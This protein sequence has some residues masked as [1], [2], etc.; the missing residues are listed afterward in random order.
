MGRPPLIDNKHLLQAAREV[1]IK[2]GSSGSTREIAKLLGISEAAIFKRYPTKASLFL[3]AMQPPRP[4]M[5]IIFAETQGSLPNL[6]KYRSIAYATVAY[7]RLAIPVMLP[8][9][10]HPDIG[11]DE[12]LNHYG[13]NPA[14]E[15]TENIAQWLGK[16]SAAQNPMA[17]AGFLVSALHSIAQFEVMGIHGGKLP[18]AALD[19]MITS[20]WDGIGLK[21]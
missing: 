4:D 11:L 18:D 16:N 13:H 12:L 14:L 7:F 17:A 10:S 6:Q 1:F 15:L 9:M 8:L 20:H 19:A 2:S 5:Q 21:D 3:A